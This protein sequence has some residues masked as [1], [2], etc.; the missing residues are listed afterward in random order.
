M[1]ST[2][3]IPSSLADFDPYTPVL[4]NY[5]APSAYLQGDLESGLLE[6]RHGDRLL[7]LPE[8]LLRGIY[9]G[10]EYETG[11]AAGNSLIGF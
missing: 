7:A 6:S 8:A 4:A 1:A 10:L 3:P 5:Y 11:Q 2:P 9:T